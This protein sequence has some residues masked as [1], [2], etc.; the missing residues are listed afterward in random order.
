L[1][2][3]IIAHLDGAVLYLNLLGSAVLAGPDGPVTGRAAYRRRIALLAVLAL[4]RG[5]PV[6]RERLMALLWPEH[7]SAAARH[8]LSESL[9]VLRKELGDG[10]LASV[11]DDVALAVDGLR[12]DVEV[13]RA[14]IETGR[15]EEAVGAYGGPLLDGFHV[16]DA[17]EFERWVDAERDR[18]ARAYLDALE[19]LA[20][21]AETEGG[22]LAAVDGWR[23]LA[24]G[25]PYSSRAALRLAQ[26]L[27]AAG[28]R[29]AALRAVET[30]TARLREELEVEPDA[31]LAAFAERLR[32]DPP[33]ATAPV[34]PPPAAVPPVALHPAET[35]DGSADTPVVPAAAA[36]G[37]RLDA[38][39]AGGQGARGGSGAAVPRPWGSGRRRYG[40]GA[41][42]LAAGL[43]TLAAEVFLPGLR[44]SS[45]ERAAGH[46]PRRIA[47]LYF[48]DD[49]PGHDLG[50]LASGL[51]A[52]LIDALGRVPALEVVSQNA[53]RAYRD[54][55][56]TLDSLVRTFR[57]GTMVEGS[58]QRAGDSVRVLV[59][60]V[61]TGRQSR[62]D[63]GSI[64]RPLDDLPGLNAAV[65]EEIGTALRRRLGREVEL[66]RMTA[67]TRSREALELVL[68]AEDARDQATRV[69]RGGHALDLSSAATIL[70]RA[71]SV[72]DRAERADPRWA[73]PAALRAR[74]A[75]LRADVSPAREEPRLMRAAIGHAGRA[76]L[77]APR[78]ADA[79]VLR[80]RAEWRL[81]IGAGDAGEERRWRDAAEHDVRAAL[82]VDD[83]HAEAWAT[84]GIVL[85]F[86]G[87]QEEGALAEQRA[88]DEDAFLEHA[89]RILSRQFY[90]AMSRGDY[91]AARELCARGRT[92]FHDGWRAAECRLTLLRE[93]PSLPPDAAQAWALVS[94]L[95]RL[96][97]SS[98]ARAGNRPY[99]PLAR[100]MAVAGVLARAG[101]ADSARAVTARVRVLA[102]GDAALRVP[103]LYDEAYVAL[104][105][106]DR[107]G[108]R[109]LLDRYLDAHP[110]MRDFVA[111]DVV[112]G[113][114]YAPA[115]VPPADP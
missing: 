25:D 9:H 37:V 70:A 57:V 34:P 44:S 105:S 12:T 38:P 72:L 77:R 54:G 99:A 14:G 85:R 55:D 5:R 51:T 3:G 114:L 104:L 48:S 58:V 83:T 26:A 7:S 102:A 65:G 110:A 27:E 4:A 95:D 100:R 30:H 96:D 39:R 109:R 18:L 101:L 6:A 50:Y 112:F 56:V 46:D 69:A 41:A 75:L 108:A 20:C 23:R 11:G 33:R 43:L 15:L 61:D 84:L 106:G 63:G 76:L 19:R 74:V 40:M 16:S 98:R 88:R 89:E 49:S 73:R 13:F 47:V 91:A 29:A 67:E 42:T 82:E 115:P 111:R 60:L 36:D 22:G 79:R 64:V 45:G 93:D 62:V 92:A 31:A 94:E 53:V 24:V 8:S 90:G 80:A 97:P 59:R 68:R 52:E 71:D 2:A 1:P 113:S 103:L 28:E 66:R 10:V 86:H 32:A 35:E 78:H 17:P 107:A 21:R 87:R 81:A